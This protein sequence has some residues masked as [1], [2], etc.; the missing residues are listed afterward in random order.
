MLVAVGPLATASRGRSWGQAALGVLQSWAPGPVT[1][2]Q[3]QQ[4]VRPRSPGHTFR[5]RPRQPCVLPV[6]SARGPAS[7]DHHG[8]RVGSLATMLGHSCPCLGGPRLPAAM[9]PADSE[10]LPRLF[11]GPWTAAN[12]SHGMHPDNT[13]VAH[14]ES[15]RQERASGGRGDIWISQPSPPNG[16]T[17]VA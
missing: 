17:S 3:V 4:Q 15:D 1:V 13:E 11:V 6:A 12:A 5:G 7:R 10:G 9:P 14:A 8:A 16:S 2:L